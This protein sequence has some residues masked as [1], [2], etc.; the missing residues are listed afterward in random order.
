[1]PEM[2]FR[3]GQNNVLG[4]G[5]PV[6]AL[7]DLARGVRPFDFVLLM[8]NHARPGPFRHSKTT[9]DLDAIG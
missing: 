5:H 8:L 4:F 3:S 2:P 9:L 6:C 7:G 1:M